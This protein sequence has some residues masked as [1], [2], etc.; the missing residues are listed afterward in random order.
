MTNFYLFVLFLR[1]DVLKVINSPR[2]SDP[3]G[4]ENSKNSMEIQ[5]LP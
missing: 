2:G 3:F 4:F 5:P 1:E